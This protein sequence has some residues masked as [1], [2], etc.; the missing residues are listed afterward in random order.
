MPFF[1][2]YNIA[3]KQIK[4][5]GF[6]STA[7]S[8]LKMRLSYNNYLMV[9]HDKGLELDIYDISNDYKLYAS[10]CLPINFV[11]YIHKYNLIKKNG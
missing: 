10:F 7:H 8:I 11:N 3:N 1:L 4:E 2:V 9:L 6:Q 5:Y